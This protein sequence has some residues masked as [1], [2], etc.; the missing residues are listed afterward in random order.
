MEVVVVGFYPC[1]AMCFFEGRGRELNTKGSKATKDH[2]EDGVNHCDDR[3][4]SQA[5]C[6]S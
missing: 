5:V 2:E 1:A 6:E 3:V 4:G